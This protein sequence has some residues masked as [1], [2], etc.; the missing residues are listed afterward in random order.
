FIYNKLNNALGNVLII[1]PKC[2]NITKYEFI[3]TNYNVTN[4]TKPVI[5]ISDK[6]TQRDI[7][8][9]KKWTYVNSA[10]YQESTV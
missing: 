4:V 8:N 5:Q 9:I 1:H 3:I 2:N 10:M 7:E 6:I